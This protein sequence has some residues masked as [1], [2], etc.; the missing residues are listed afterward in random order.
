M[1]SRAK[2][3]AAG[4]AATLLLAPAVLG[5]DE[6]EVQS[7]DALDPMEVGLPDAWMG[8]TLW[9]GTDLGLALTVM[10]R[11]PAAT[12]GAYESGATRELARA[13][14]S[15]GGYPPSGG[16]GNA[17]LSVMRTD[18]LL[19]AAGA[20]DTF[21][22]LER[23]PNIN[24]NAGLAHM[25]TELAFALGEADRG[26][27]TANALLADR[28]QAK[29]VRVRAFCLAVS[30]QGAAAELTAEL[31]SSI[32]PDPDF[33]AMLYGIT[34]E[35]APDDGLPAIETG[36]DYAMARRLA[37]ISGETMTLAETAP[38]W[39]REIVENNATARFAIEGDPATSLDEARD[40]EGELRQGLLDAVL[41]QGMDRELAAEALRLMLQD[42]REGDDFLSAARRY[43]HD[44]DTLPVTRSS[45]DG[46]FDFAL[47]ALMVGDVRTARRWRDALIDG[48]PRPAPP[49]PVM[50]PGPDGTMIPEPQAEPVFEEA[51]AWV[52]IA[53]D[54]LVLLDLAIAVAG[55]RLRG[56]QLDAVN[57]AYL[58]G[59]GEAG[60]PEI[61]AVTRLGA[62]PPEALRPYL[63]DAAAHPGGVLLAM[64]AAARANAHA[65]T[66]LLAVIALNEAGDAVS[67]DT[68]SRVA[69]A[70]DAI[71]L[72]DAALYLVLEQIIQRAA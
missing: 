69:T 11:L 46:G 36:L 49:P 72:R 22:L 12:D 41:A 44:V 30:G 60:L 25:H 20:Y 51:D 33:D 58:E 40:A 70:L 17:T 13:V 55:D 4:L 29:W 64:E 8:S 34:L 43:G 9:D 31:A 50:K 18:R 65:E 26:C 2:S 16:R 27:N 61:L 54:Q 68:L 63:L 14:L 52:P 7:L 53:G 42:A 38:R 56:D 28:E 19:A 71:D 57:A 37:A 5:Q 45:L 6:I 48:P 59:R 39:L 23:T 47:A 32:E 24:Q 10:A 62:N 15:T 21:D 1:I 3:A 66:A 67:A 35:T